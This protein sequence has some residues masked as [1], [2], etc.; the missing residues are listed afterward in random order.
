[1]IR[2][3]SEPAIPGNHEPHT[4]SG[5][6]FVVRKTAFVSQ[7]PVLKLATPML[8]SLSL[9]KL[10]SCEI[11]SSPGDQTSSLQSQRHESTQPEKVTPQGQ[12]CQALS[13]DQDTCQASA[14]RRDEI[15][16]NR[17]YYR[18]RALRRFV[19]RF[20]KRGECVCIPSTSHPRC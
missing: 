20:L 5:R 7:R 18:P 12:A 1:M 8:P 6:D 9:A 15:A 3:R 16:K 17:V 19:H 13:K 4:Q 2:D 14:C 11:E 10:S